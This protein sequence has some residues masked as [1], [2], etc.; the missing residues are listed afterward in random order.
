[1]GRFGAPG[2]LI[3]ARAGNTAG[4]NLNKALDSAHPRSRGEHN[5]VEPC[6]NVLVGSPP[7]ARG[8]HSA[9]E[10]E[11]TRYRLT[12]ARAGNTA[13]SP[14]VSAA[15]SAH[16]RS[17]GEHAFSDE[18]SGSFSGSPPLA[19]GTPVLLLGRGF[20]IR[21]TPAR[22][23]NTSSRKPRGFART[24]HPRSRGEHIG[25]HCVSRVS[26]GSPPLAR[27][28]PGGLGIAG[29]CGRLTPARAGNTAQPNEA[30]HSSAAHPR[31]RGEH[32]LRLP[33]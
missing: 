22:A 3:P 2:R 16:P 14:P 19:R 5:R 17:R 4:P 32:C 11:H 13:I 23:G 18:L 21:L 25:A 15:S 1:M 33:F 29:F 9:N 12:P 6:A 7:L 24:A 20:S 8:T 31:S 27:G 28:T 26:F 10:R 30:S